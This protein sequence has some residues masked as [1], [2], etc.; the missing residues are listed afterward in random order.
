V[1]GAGTC[2]LAAGMLL[3]REGH[4]VTILERDCDRV[5]S[6]PS[7]AWERWI[8][9]GVSQF[10]Q[11]HFLQSRGRIVLEQELPDVV[12]ALEAAGALRFDPL[13][14]MPPLI[15]DRTPREGDERFRTI[16]ARRPVLE[17]VLSRAVDAEPG[18]QI[19]R[20]VP[21]RSLVLQAHNGVPHVGGVRTDD[22][23]Q[24]RADLVVD[25][26]GRRSQ[27]PRWLE[28]AGTRPVH[29]EA[30]NSGFIYYTRY[31]RSR[32]GARPQYKAPFL[33]AVGTFSLLTLP[34]DNHTWS[35]TVFTS[36]G[37]APLKRLRHPDTWAAVV[38]A[39][40]R[41]AHWL[42]GDPITG[43]LAMGGVTN[44]YRRLSVDNHPVATGIATVG[45]AAACTNPTNGR[46][47]SL[48]LMHVQHLRD[49][50]R[51]HLHDPLEFAHAWDAVT[52]AELVPW[53]RDNVE[54]DRARLGEIEALHNGCEPPPADSSSAVLRRA[55]LAAVPHDPDAFR[56]VLASLCCLTPLRS[57]FNNQRFVERILEL[58]NDAEPP[59]PSGPNRTQL[60]QLLNG[61]ARR[62][63]TRKSDRKPPIRTPMPRVRGHLPAGAP[64]AT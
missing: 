33:T 5:P 9:T 36:A 63:P 15:T 10:R 4:E 35:V 1:L 11:P 19:R 23:E 25:A 34:C 38:S 57:T 50:I 7:E 28:R 22:G 3:R 12:V 41:H 58:A 45:D 64:A 26:M 14:L 13:C 48:G 40:P 8:R 2:G 49:V 62:D 6:S 16:T 30:E 47:M 24:L 31:F 60:L 51:T 55:L 61:A 56:A 52:E 17:Q 46:G 37:D 27:L 59:P 21:V 18:L 32:D 29:E 20:G 42:D 43:V 53:Y 54:A 44:R 39:C